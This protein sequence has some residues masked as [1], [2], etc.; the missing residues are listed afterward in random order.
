MRGEGGLVGLERIAPAGGGERGRHSLEIAAIGVDGVA[1]AAALD[2]ERLEEALERPPP[3][4]IVARR[5]WQLP[6]LPERSRRHPGT[7]A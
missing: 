6:I 3:G 1:R 5:R 7:G 2:C 4:C